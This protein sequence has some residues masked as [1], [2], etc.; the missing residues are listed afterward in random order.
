M[1]LRGIL[2]LLLCLSTAVPEEAHGFFFRMIQNMRANRMARQRRRMMPR[3]CMSR[4]C[5]PRRNQFDNGFIDGS[6]N[7]LIG[8]SD[9]GLP[10]VQTGGNGSGQLGSDGRVPS[11]A[12]LGP[13]TPGEHSIDWRQGTETTKKLGTYSI[14]QIP[15]GFRGTVRDRKTGQV[16][17]AFVGQM[18]VVD[19]DGV[20]YTADPR[21]VAEYYK[22]YEAAPNSTAIRQTVAA[23]KPVRDEL[24]RLWSGSGYGTPPGQTPV[25]GGH[26]FPSP[27]STPDGRPVVAV[28]GDSQYDKWKKQFVDDT[29]ASTKDFS[30]ASA[31]LAQN[32][33]DPAA[34]WQASVI[35]QTC[36]HKEDPKASSNMTLVLFTTPDGKKLRLT[37]K[38]GH[39]DLD[40]AALAN[41]WKNATADEKG[42]D[43]Q[44]ETGELKAQNWTLNGQ[45][46]SFWVNRFSPDAKTKLLGYDEA[47]IQVKLLK[48]DARTPVRDVITRYVFRKSKENPGV[49]NETDFVY[50]CK[51]STPAIAPAGTP[52]T[53]GTDTSKTVPKGAVQHASEVQAI[54]QGG[55]CNKCHGQGKSQEGFARVDKARALE[56]A[57][58]VNLSPNDPSGEF[59]PQNGQP[60]SQ[61]AMIKAWAESMQ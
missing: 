51:R 61:A 28:A 27:S 21:T 10:V 41:E 46:H 39:V 32:S 35:Q 24:Q 43:P 59:M 9:G 14:R 33:P 36:M 48:S 30:L 8:S 31:I 37:M 56:I 55:A 47:Q 6:N 1:K 4:G 50:Y 20:Y 12:L 44:T 25:A 26:S 18:V 60:L 42:F 53:T 52:V 19:Q 40:K 17:Q 34:K 15:S 58:R 29:Y 13:M 7:Q 11:S 45:K 16:V 38:E 5:Q 23:Y 2:I 54:L 49:G 3:R 22:R 57:R